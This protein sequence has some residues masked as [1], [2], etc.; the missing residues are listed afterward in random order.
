MVPAIDLIDLWMLARIHPS[1]PSGALDDAMVVVTTLGS[2]WMLLALIPSLLMRRTRRAATSLLC[3]VLVTA[4]LVFAL[5]RAVGR[6]RPCNAALSI[7]PVVIEAPTDPSFPSGHAGGTFTVAG[8]LLVALRRRR[9]AWSSARVLATAAS[10][11]ALAGSI[12][13]SRVYLGV[14]FPSDV[15]AGALLGLTIGALAARRAL[16]DLSAPEAERAAIARA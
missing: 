4:T 11:G 12:G 9:A 7:A 3:A 16:G 2:G 15:A 14:H 10:L 1:A 8:F 13:L 6:V 5:K